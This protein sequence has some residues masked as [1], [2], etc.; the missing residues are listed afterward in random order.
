MP[1]AG[2]A[3]LTVRDALHAAVA[4]HTG[5]E[6]I[7]TYDRDFDHIAGLRRIEP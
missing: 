5:A 3:P 2:A 1:R 6:A 7:C 4:L